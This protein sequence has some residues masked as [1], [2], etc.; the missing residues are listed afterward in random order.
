MKRVNYTKVYG[1]LGKVLCGV[2][3]GIVGFLA[4]GVYVAVAG[5]VAGLVV[6]HLSEK[7]VV[8]PAMGK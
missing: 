7:A 8:N 6:G 2:A 3:G 4:A 5:V 1:L